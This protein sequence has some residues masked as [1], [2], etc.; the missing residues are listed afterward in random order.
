MEFD[1]EAVFLRSTTS[2]RLHVTQ[3]GI[4]EINQRINYLSVRKSEEK[5]TKAITISY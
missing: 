1:Q 3:H 2:N 4:N 5:D